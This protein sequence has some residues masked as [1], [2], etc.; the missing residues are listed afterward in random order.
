MIWSFYFYLLCLYAPPIGIVSIFP[1]WIFFTIFFQESVY[2]LKQLYKRMDPA[3]MKTIGEAKGEVK[4][5]FKY[6]EKRG[7][8][9]V[10][11]VCARDLSAK[12]LRGNTIDPYVKVS[13]CW[14]N[15]TK[16]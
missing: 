15:F 4:L 13:K 7:A 10:K 12:D 3:V 5:S 16:T 9:L 1:Q 2:I 6:N 11:V 8:L 14:I